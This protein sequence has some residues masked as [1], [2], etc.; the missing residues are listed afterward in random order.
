MHDIVKDKELEVLLLFDTTAG[1]VSIV[2]KA[3]SDLPTHQIY[4]NMMQK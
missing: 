3:S 2:L 1:K 4:S